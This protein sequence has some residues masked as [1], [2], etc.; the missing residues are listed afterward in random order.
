MGALEAFVRAFDSSGAYAAAEPAWCAQ[1]RH[2]AREDL[3]R[4]GLPTRHTEDWKYT[5]LR[6]LDAIDL[7]TT[8]PT[9]L[10]DGE[11][12]RDAGALLVGD[13]PRLVFV[14][15]A[16]DAELSHLSDLPPGVSLAPWGAGLSHNATASGAV[17]DAAARGGAFEAI[18]RLFA[19][20]GMA[21]ELAD[22]VCLAAPVV[23]IALQTRA[24][25]S[26]LR[27]VLRLGQGSW[28]RVIEQ[29]IGLAQMV[30]Y[31]STSVTRAELA[32][33]ATLAHVRLQD[34]SGAAVHVSQLHVAQGRD[35]RL[36]ARLLVVGARLSRQEF[37]I[38]H[39]APGCHTDLRGASVLAGE[40]HGD[41][42]MCIEHRHPRSTSRT[43]VRGVFDDASHGV[44]TGRVN[45]HP[46]AQKT[47]AGM[48]NRNLLL[49]PRAE[50]DTRPQ[51]QI[52]A[53]DVLCSHGATVG[54]LDA[55]AL[56]YLQSRGIAAPLAR[57]L[58]VQAFVAQALPDIGWEPL[59]AQVRTRLAA[60]RG[61]AIEA[62]EVSA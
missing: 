44:F 2:Q 29:H 56:F 61:L 10:L 38:A 24:G 22:G 42:H 52:D 31:L 32:R 5:S 35:S 1:A 14:D 46:G 57:A 60:R 41:V 37:H 7:A 15:G 3:L 6:A 48:I 53:D 51:L 26:H 11:A 36:D 21:L 23:V 47:D 28:A 49:S 16:F 18:N 55:E 50:A 20:D 19:R 9:A 33:G 25:A 62:S 4:S 30:P 13:G 40:Q 39:E 45:V 43:D 27:H 54:Q 34:E 12:L 58:L 17:L 59:R 8:A